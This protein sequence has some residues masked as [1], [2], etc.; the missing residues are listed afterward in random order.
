[1]SN[2]EYIDLLIVG[3]GPAGLST[4]MHL[5]KIDPS[6]K[7][8]LIILEKSEHPRSKICGGGVTQFGLK[9]LR[10]LGFSLPLPLSQ[11]V[12]NYLNLNYHKRTIHVQGE[13]LFNV[14]NRPEFDQ[15]L[16][17]NAK[18]RGIQI[19]ENEEVKSL[20]V[21]KDRIKVN[22]TKRSY[23]TA[24]VV[25]ADGSS[26]IVR[27]YVQGKNKQKNLARTLKIWVHGTFSSPRFKGQSALFDFSN[28]SNR[29]SGY[30]W[31]FPNRIGG[32]PGYNQGVYESR[33]VR[34][35]PPIKLTN[36]LDHN[37]PRSDSKDERPILES[38]PIHWF[39]PKY[40][41]SDQRIILTG[42]AA[43]VDVLFGEGI[44]PA[45][46]YGKIASNEI[47]YAFRKNEFNLRGYKTNLL[48]SELG[49]YLF[50]RWLLAVLVYRYGHMPFFTHTVWSISQVLAYFWRPGQI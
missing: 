43:G 25:G 30:T 26:G 20:E 47:D 46:G 21:L 15:Y 16:A 8:R 36:I 23:E 39:N 34:T 19:R 41:I 29:F 1:M 6:W 38:A 18:S 48:I 5:L 9:I 27:K 2:S 45:L 35:K 49:R 40:P 13:P 42:D 33:I 32:S 17:T 4:A 10:E 22:T 3:A 28:L 7:E 50:I 14:Y 31:D 11:D 12:V 24:L 37:F 44:G